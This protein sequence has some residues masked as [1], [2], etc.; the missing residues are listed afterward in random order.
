MFILVRNETFVI[1]TRYESDPTIV[2]YHRYIYLS[3][4]LL[5][6]THHVP[7]TFSSP[8]FLQQTHHNF[9]YDKYCLLHATAI[10]LNLSML[11]LLIA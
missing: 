1:S 10:L 5:L 6:P 2:I 8:S 4:I 3:I 7:S 11:C 9:I